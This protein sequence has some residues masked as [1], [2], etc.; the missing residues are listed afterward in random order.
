MKDLICLLATVRTH[1]LYFW[2]MI[3]FVQNAEEIIQQS[4][5]CRNK[6]LSFCADIMLYKS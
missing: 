1:K 2:V 5:F 4:D 3:L 6:I